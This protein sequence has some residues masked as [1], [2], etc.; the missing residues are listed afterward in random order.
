MGVGVVKVVVLPNLDE[1]LLRNVRQRSET[2]FRRVFLSYILKFPFPSVRPD[3]L[4]FAGIAPWIH[5]SAT[6]LDTPSTTALICRLSVFL[7]P[8][9]GGI[10][11]NY[12]EICHPH[13][14]TILVMN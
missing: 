3:S 12:D 6:A 1:Y 13:P 7:F 11:R 2:R 9:S 14:H 8:I 4:C 5:L 10:D